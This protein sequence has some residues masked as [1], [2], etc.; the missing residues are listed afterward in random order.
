MV[1]ADDAVTQ[2]K[3]IFLQQGSR[4]FFPFSKKE[5]SWQPVQ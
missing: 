4:E 1:G 3:A 5:E 2:E